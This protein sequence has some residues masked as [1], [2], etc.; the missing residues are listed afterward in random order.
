MSLE[1]PAE[2]RSSFFIEADWDVEAEE[3]HQHHILHK[4][5]A[6]ASQNRLKEA[7]DLFSVA[8][9]CAPARPEQLSTFADCI[10]RN[11]KNKVSGTDPDQNRRD[12]FDCP[13]CHCFLGEAV[14]IACGHSYCKRCLERRLLSKCK[15][16]SEAVQGDEKA[17]VVL[18]GLLERWF[19]EEL[20]RSK[21]TGEVD[22]LCQGKRYQEAVSLATRIIESDAESTAVVRLSR[23]EAYMA[24]KQYR[25]ALEDIESCPKS[26][27]SAETLFRKAMV[28]HAMGHVDESLQV[29][30]HCLAV[31]ED[32]PCTK[33]QVEKILC[34]L[35]S[36]AYE[37]VKVSL[38]ETTQNTLPH[39]R[40]KIHTAD[41][42]SQ[43]QTPVQRPQQHQA[44]AASVNQQENNEKRCESLER[45]GLSRAHSLRIHCNTS[46]EGLKRVCSAPQLGD[47]DKGSLLKRKLSVSDTEPC[48]I[49]SGGSKHKKQGLTTSSKHLATKDK[50]CRKVPEDLLDPNELECSLCMRLFYE[51]VTTPCGHTFC[52]KCLE[53]CL[54]HTPQCPLCKESLKEYLAC[55]K[56][57]VTT[58]LETLIKQ[59]LS[60]EYAERTKT[61]MEETRELS[62]LTKNVPI[63]VCTMAYPT[64]PCPLHV[65]E[66]RYRLMIRRC[67][68]TGTRQF[69]MCINDP[70]NSFS[71][72][73][74]MLIIR[75]VHF[76]PDGR[77]VVDTIG[78]KRFRVLSRGMKDGYCTADIEHLE[79]SR[80]ED[81][82][83]LEKL[84]ELHDEV[85]EQARA[86]F[87]NL[88]I[89]F[90]NQI[91]QHFGP[92]PERED[93]IQAT[94]NGPACCWWL[95]AVL[96]IDP[97]YQLSVLSMT[98]LKERL[99]KIQHILTYLQSIPNN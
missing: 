7:L 91:L 14:T 94:P 12:A 73:G 81:T 59:H 86:W 30:L 5:N 28:L 74:C 75:S 56:Y 34:D 77:S 83:E 57:M 64:V 10:V 17:N 1:P 36:P 52:K 72:Y 21:S 79:D 76:L 87:Q 61:H 96:P 48:V 51:P 39:L 27:V 54:D 69:G 37:N 13:N 45:P 19:P 63:F 50:T 66:P 4:A 9:R 85:Y 8:L 92:M 58:I 70:Q 46:D 99:V 82:S 95:L 42:K 47:Q 25:L 38:R 22:A 26:S 49:D 20:K 44:R 67:M 11:F 31:D 43:P 55:R 23:A 29:F 33:R 32:F 89:H 65:F 3:D 80:V 93:D 97:R 78:G 88:K 98:S 68:D 90:H 71:D 2:D 53:R 16:C 84:Q 40:S 24:L 18:C 6:L 60:Q 35:L 15:L 62:D 41:A